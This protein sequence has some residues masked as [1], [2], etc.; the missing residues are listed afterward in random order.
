MTGARSKMLTRAIAVSVCL[1]LCACV[2]GGPPPATSQEGEAAQTKWLDC[3]IQAAI[4]LDDHRS[5]AS[6][7][8]MAVASACAKE[9]VASAETY[10]RG[11]TLGAAAIFNS[12]AESRQ[13]QWATTAVLK[14]RAGEVYRDPSR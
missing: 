10:T 3:M 7:V 8:A 5:D 2:S 12:K 6:T 9:Y 4:R 11:M 14:E 13:M 1:L